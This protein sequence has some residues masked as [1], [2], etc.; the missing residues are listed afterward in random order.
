LQRVARSWQVLL[1]AIVSTES[2]SYFE[3]FLA[4]ESL[5][6]TSTSPE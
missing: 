4:R 2:L 3:E 5:R 1:P 6:H